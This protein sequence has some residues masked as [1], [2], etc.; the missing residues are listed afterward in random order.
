MTHE[1]ISNIV[2]VVLDQ[3]LAAAEPEAD[4]AP[5]MD[6]LAAAPPDA[7]PMLDEPEPEPE[8]EP[9]LDEKKESYMS[10][11]GAASTFVPGTQMPPDDKDMSRMSKLHEEAVLTRYQKQL[12]DAQEVI[13]RQNERI[14]KLER[15]GRDADRSARLSL[16]VSQGVNVDP[17]DELEFT[18]DFDDA[19]FDAYVGRIKERYSRDTT[20]TPMLET[21]SPK[22]EKAEPT[23]D[24]V[25]AAIL[26]AA[27]N[28]YRAT[29]AVVRYQRAVSEGK[30]P[31][32]SFYLERH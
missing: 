31:S 2:K 23:Q 15:L 26:W 20:K 22:S 18:K 24:E 1:E 9:E 8:A 25:S 7:G 27:E 32:P 14:A 21:E 10:G 5:D 17:A 11:P 30:A 6:P 28:G 3:L 29:D 4:A 19:K 13:K 12:D 16:L